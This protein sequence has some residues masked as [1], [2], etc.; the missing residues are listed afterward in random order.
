MSPQRSFMK[1]GGDYPV[2]PPSTKC[3][4][5]RLSR[6]SVGIK[7]HDRKSP[8][9]RMSNNSTITYVFP[10][11]M[12]HKRRDSHGPH[13]WRSWS[14]VLILLHPRTDEGHVFFCNGQWDT[15]V[16]NITRWTNRW[17]AIRYE[18]TLIFICMRSNLCAEFGVVVSERLKSLEWMAV[19]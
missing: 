2:I 13:W 7:P 8:V 4:F 19:S 3:M 6:P 9:I 1:A 11:D 14:V 12:T 18:D 5:T 17:E 16:N 15:L 10:L